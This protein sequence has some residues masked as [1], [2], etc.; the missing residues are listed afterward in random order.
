M[1]HEDEDN[2]DDDEDSDIDNSSFHEDSQIS[3]MSHSKDD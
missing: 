3:E 1:E 2:D